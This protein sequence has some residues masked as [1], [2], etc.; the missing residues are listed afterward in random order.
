MWYDN[1]KGVER[2]SRYSGYFVFFIV[3]FIVAVIRGIGS[4]GKKKTDKQPAKSPA[5]TPIR[6]KP[7]K[8]DCDY[9]EVNHHY[10]HETDRRIAQVNAYL[11]AGLIDKTEYRQ[12]LER[13]SKADNFLDN[14]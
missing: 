3:Y 6:K 5:P 10:S 4:Q 8:D 2:M 12:M 13:Y 11:K 1:P 7:P 14:Y 9:G